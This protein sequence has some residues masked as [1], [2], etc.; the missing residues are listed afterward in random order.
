MV[1]CIS[2]YCIFFG[3]ASY[4][5]VFT[6]KIEN[7]L[8]RCWCDRPDERQIFGEIFDHFSGDISYF[9]E[10]VERKVNLMSNTLRTNSN[11]P[12]SSYH[13]NI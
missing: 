9:K 2:T 12:N 10:I 1:K 8:K 6:E 7:L 13:T 3:D 11:G 4:A 5:I